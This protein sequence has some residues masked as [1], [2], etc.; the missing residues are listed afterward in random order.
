MKYAYESGVGG[1]GSIEVNTANMVGIPMR[2]ITQYNADDE[3]TNL[4]SGNEVEYSAFTRIGIDYIKPFRFHQVKGGNMLRNY[5]LS[6]DPFPGGL[7]V[8]GIRDFTVFETL[9]DNYTQYI[10]NNDLLEEVKIRSNILGDQITQY[11]YNTLRQLEHITDHNGQITE[12]IYDG[13]QRLDQIKSGKGTGHTASDGTVIAPA[14][15]GFRKITDY[16]YYYMLDANGDIIPNAENKIETTVSFPLDP[17][18]QNQISRFIS[19]GLGREIRSEKDNFDANATNTVVL[20]TKQYDDYGR[21]WKDTNLGSGTAIYTYENAPT[22]RLLQVITP[23]NVT[24][25]EYGNNPN[26]G[27]SVDGKTYLAGSLSWALTKVY[28]RNNE[29][30][31]QADNFSDFMGREVINTNFVEKPAGGLAAVRTKMA[32]NNLNQLEK[33]FPHLGEHYEYTYNQRGLLASKTI[34]NKGTMN[35][36]Y[37]KLERQIASEDPAGNTFVTMYDDLGREIVTGLK[38]T[39]IGHDSDTY[40]NIVLPTAERHNSTVYHKDNANNPIDWVK[41]TNTKN[42]TN[43]NWLPTFMDN[44]DDLGRLLKSTSRNHKGNSEI[45][46]MTYNDADLLTYNKLS[47]N[48]NTA[49]PNNTWGTNLVLEWE[50]TFDDA[51]RPKEVK[52]KDLTTNILEIGGKKLTILMIS[53]D[54]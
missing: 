17:S 53:P 24:K 33:I 3:V 8:S 49:T 41:H 7:N 52:F 39:S 2:T 47:H 28:N 30:E 54:V 9:D 48:D 21:L 43:G 22:N 35:Y 19:D 50:N 16:D 4:I 10:W 45:N 38:L 12:F 31:S 37:D 46:E 5:Q 13:L 23:T 27:H 40:T 32:Y 6:Y 25:T 11:N 15:T 18:L 44:Y 26:N 34:P 36:W 51:F 14:G 42:L 1:P 29:L 20:N